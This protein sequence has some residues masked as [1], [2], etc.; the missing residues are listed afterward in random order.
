MADFL[1]SN[2]PSMKKNLMKDYSNFRKKVTGSVIGEDETKKLI[3]QFATEKLKE[4]SGAAISEKELS[5]LK[6][7]IGK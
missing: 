1:K 5:I 2:F 7:I 3:N 4:I 6:S